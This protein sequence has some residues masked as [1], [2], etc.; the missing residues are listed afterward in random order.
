VWGEKHSYSYPENQQGRDNPGEK[1]KS[2]HRLRVG[3]VLSHKKGSKGKKQDF[4]RKALRRGVKTLIIGN[5]HQ[6]EKENH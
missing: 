4:F 1:K 5:N 3:G 2:R 6:G